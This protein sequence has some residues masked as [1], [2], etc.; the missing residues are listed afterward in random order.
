MTVILSGGMYSSV[1]WSAQKQRIVAQ[2]STEAEYVAR[3]LTPNEA[4][5]IHRLLSEVKQTQLN[6]TNLLT[7]NQ[8]SI[9]LTHNPIFHKA[10]PHPKLTTT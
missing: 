3:A 7:N 1:S 10:G 9:S 4:I 8:A 2:S 5:W 6:A